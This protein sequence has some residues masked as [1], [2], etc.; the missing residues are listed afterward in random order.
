MRLSCLRKLKVLYERVV[1]VEDCA[2]RTENGF[3]HI[4]LP[5]NTFDSLDLGLK[6]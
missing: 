2:F 4:S 6:R 5:R 1:I 3:N